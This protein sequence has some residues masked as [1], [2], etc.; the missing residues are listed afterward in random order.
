MTQ[1]GNF[2]IKLLSKFKEDLFLSLIIFSGWSFNRS[3]YQVFSFSGHFRKNVQ[4]ESE[5]VMVSNINMN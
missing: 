3:F 5:D 2:H 4:A 1:W